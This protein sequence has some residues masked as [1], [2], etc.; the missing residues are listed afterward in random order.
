MILEVFNYL[1]QVT[2]QDEDQPEKR[3]PNQ[4]H[5]NQIT[6]ILSTMFF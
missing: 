5:F 1:S 2:H 3:E 4:I 6:T